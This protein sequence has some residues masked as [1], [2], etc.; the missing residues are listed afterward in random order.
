MWNLRLSCLSHFLKGRWDSYMETKKCICSIVVPRGR[1]SKMKSELSFL[2]TTTSSQLTM[3]QHFFWWYVSFQLK[4]GHFK[5]IKIYL[6]GKLRKSNTRSYFSIMK[7]NF[8]SWLD[9][10]YTEMISNNETPKCKFLFEHKFGAFAY[11][12]IRYL[13][14]DYWFSWKV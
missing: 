12:L 7:L 6:H 14:I 11:F 3:S 5:A 8:S 9:P 13:K 2:S 4:N 10:I 1:S